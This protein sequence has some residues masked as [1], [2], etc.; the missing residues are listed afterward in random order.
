MRNCVTVGRKPLCVNSPVVSWIHRNARHAWAQVCP[1][2]PASLTLHVV[3]GLRLEPAQMAG[4]T[5]DTS[6]KILLPRTPMWKDAA[7]NLAP[8]MR[9]EGSLMMHTYVM[10]V[11]M[12]FQRTV[13]RQPDLAV[14]L[15]KAAAVEVEAEEARREV[16]GQM[17]EPSPTHRIHRHARNA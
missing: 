16:A 10:A 2:V 7:Q 12:K 4:S 14:V 9:S 5:A 11:L 8:G 17:L 6:P 13:H 3:L 1:L 15:H